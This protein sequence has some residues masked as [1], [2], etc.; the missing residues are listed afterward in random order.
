MPDEASLAVSVQHIQRRGN[1]CHIRAMVFFD[2][3]VGGCS[4]HDDP[5]AFPACAHI[6]LQL[7]LQ[8]GVTELR[9]ATD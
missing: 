8:N 1:C 2:E 4:C 3:I 6:D 5:E 7:D 9:A